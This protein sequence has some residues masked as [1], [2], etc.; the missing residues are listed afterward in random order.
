MGAC[1]SCEIIDDDARREHT[2]ILAEGPSH[3]SEP[4]G[5]FESPAPPGDSPPG[6]R[7]AANEGALARARSASRIGRRRYVASEVPAIEVSA[8]VEPTTAAPQPA[9]PEGG[10]RV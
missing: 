1:C 10:E 3:S 8:I 2:T 9:A 5:T 7:R 6:R 4:P